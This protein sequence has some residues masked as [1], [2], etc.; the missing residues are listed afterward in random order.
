MNTKLSKEEIE[1]L[2]EIWALIDANELTLAEHD[3]NTLAEID[4]MERFNHAKKK[5]TGTPHEL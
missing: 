4:E 2:D 5:G 1:A 3:I